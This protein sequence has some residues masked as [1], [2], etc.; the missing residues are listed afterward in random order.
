MFFAKILLYILGYSVDDTLIK[1]FKSKKG[2]IAI[3]PHTSYFEAPIIC[4]AILAYD[5][6]D[7]TCFACTETYID[8]WL[9]GWWLK[10][11]GGIAV[12]YGAN[13]KAS[14]T[15]TVIKYLKENPKKTFAISPEGSL[16]PTEWKTGFYYIA[17]ETDRNVFIFGID[18]SSHTI[19]DYYKNYRVNNDVSKERFLKIVKR[20]FSNSCI[21]PL[22]PK[23]SNPIIRNSLTKYTSILPL[24]RIFL[25]F[26]IFLIKCQPLTY[27]VK[28]SQKF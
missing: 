17:K 23:K 5:L 26:L 13:K 24:S 9:T 16:E 19:K 25:I 4:L 10:Y 21:T 27:L 14:F 6:Q 12:R 7:K 20:G 18:F 15:E 3:F 2:A 8:S 11:F 28:K 22:Y 1:R